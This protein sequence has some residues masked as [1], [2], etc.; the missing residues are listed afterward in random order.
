VRNPNNAEA[1]DWDEANEAELARHGILL[2]DVEQIWMNGPVLA[3][4]KR[5][6][7]GDWKMIGFTD[8]GR[9]LTVILRY[10]A[11]RRLLRPITGWETTD[12]ERRR[13][14]K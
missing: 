11:D 13:Y 3:P 8:G 12:G 7:A 9:L 5:R 14:Y 6:R 4:N 1:W 2:P 10:D